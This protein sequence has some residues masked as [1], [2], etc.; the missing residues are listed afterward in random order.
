MAAVARSNSDSDF[1]NP[2]WGTGAPKPD[3][4]WLGRCA[5]IAY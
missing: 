2:R 5:N 3:W 1:Y 4:S